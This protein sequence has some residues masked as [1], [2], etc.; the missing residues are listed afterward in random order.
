MV[1]CEQPMRRADSRAVYQSLIEQEVQCPVH[2]RRGWI[3]NTLPQFIQNFIRADRPIGRTHQFQHLAPLRVSFTLRS[4]HNVCQF[5]NFGEFLLFNAISICV[6]SVRW[7]PVPGDWLSSAVPG[8][9]TS[10]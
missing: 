6:W 1:G 7:C 5:Q 2:R 4:V 8:F 9:L 10:V 3:A